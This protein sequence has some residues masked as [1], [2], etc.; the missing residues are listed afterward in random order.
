MLRKTMV[1]RAFGA[2]VSNFGIP[3]GSNF[4]ILQLLLS[5]FQTQP[6]MMFSSPATIRIAS[7]RSPSHLFI[8][9]TA[10]NQFY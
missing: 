1:Q 10:Q 8:E 5:V 6:Q 3:I 7:R 2:T 9:E 4:S